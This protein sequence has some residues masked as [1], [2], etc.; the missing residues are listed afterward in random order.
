ML[1]GIVALSSFEGKPKES[2]YNIKK[3]RA[4]YSSANAAQ[5]QAPN[6]DESVKATYQ[7]IGHLPPVPYP[8]DNPASPEKVNLGR[9]LFFDPRLSSSGQI[10]CASCHDPQLGWGDGKRVAFGHDRKL[11]ER[12]AMTILNTA[13]YN[14]LFWD[15][16][17]S[18]LEDQARG[19]VQDKVEMH[20][21]LDVMEQ[22][23]KSFAGYKPLFQKAFGD[24]KIDLDRIFKAIATFERTVTSPPSRFDLFIDGKQDALTDDEV[25]G[26]HLFRTKARCVNC[27]N[28]G[29]FADNQFHNDGQTLFASP[30]EDLGLYNVTKK[31]A[32][33]GKFKT[34]SLREV[35]NTGPWM[36][37]GNFP[38]LKDVV[39][40]YNL[41]NPAPIPKSYKGGRD[42]LLPKT[43]PLLR[44]LDLTDREIN[45]LIAF[46]G[47]ITTTP[48][49]LNPPQDF[50]K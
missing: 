17:A 29:L 1:A 32:D 39:F 30:N 12:N 44:K 36:H 43:S 21:N 16:R 13:Y 41:G 4:A 26:L 28:G 7:E 42:S 9:M 15:G 10:A 37:H 35:V 47:S 14:R 49:R 34:P 8:A 48:R 5:W 2:K 22:R 19:P 46:L 38:T 20:E 18:S 33:V 23:V 11:G 6:I 45:A 3:L 31:H 25:L 40:L 24:D 27:H 50:P